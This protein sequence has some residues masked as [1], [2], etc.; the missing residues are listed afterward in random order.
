MDSIEDVFEK[1]VLNKKLA[2]HK[3]YSVKVDGHERAWMKHPK[4][5]TI[6]ISEPA[7]DSDKAWL[8]KG[9]DSW[10]FYRE[11]DSPL[12][13]SQQ[14]NGMFADPPMTGSLAIASK[15]LN[16]SPAKRLNG[17]SSY[18][19]QDQPL[20]QVVPRIYYPSNEGHQGHSTSSNQPTTSPIM[21]V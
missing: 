14:V 1:Q 9:Y 8:I 18:K 4:V 16:D 5:P 20:S 12:L 10:E 17:S 15:L 2:K 11:T 3:R 19:L 6:V 13:E 21:P 7:Q